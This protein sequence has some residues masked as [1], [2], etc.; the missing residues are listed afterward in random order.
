MKISSLKLPLWQVHTHRLIYVIFQGSIK[1]GWN[2]CMW[3]SGKEMEY[4]FS[5]CFLPVFSYLLHD[6][7]LCYKSSWYADY[8]DELAFIK[9]YSFCG[10]SDRKNSTH[11][12][13]MA[14]LHVIKWVGF[15]SV[16]GKQCSFAPEM[17]TS[18]AFDDNI[19]GYIM[20]VISGATIILLMFIEHESS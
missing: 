16:P 12:C 13:M 14:D 15:W 6:N 9:L 7:S 20:Q 17:T 5:V 1:Q 10:C 3:I 8:Q 11:C 18:T 2:S 4:M 19:K